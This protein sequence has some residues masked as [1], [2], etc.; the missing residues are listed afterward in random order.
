MRTQCLLCQSKSH[1]MDRCEY[2]HLS[3]KSSHVAAETKKTNVGGEKSDIDRHRMSGTAID[4]TTM[5]GTSDMIGTE[6][7][8]DDTSIT[9]GISPSGITNDGKITGDMTTNPVKGTATKR[10]LIKNGIS[11]KGAT[12]V[13]RK[14]APQAANRTKAPRLPQVLHRVQETMPNPAIPGKH[15]AIIAGKKDIIVIN[16]RQRAMTSD[17]Q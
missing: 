15:I 2:K 1:T 12:H 8:M 4:E 6:I 9:T 7:T 5:T 14:K 16:V 10:T 11:K 17:R 3:G 13:N